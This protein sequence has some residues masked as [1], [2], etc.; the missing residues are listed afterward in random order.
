MKPLHAALVAVAVLSLPCAR[1]RAADVAPE[2]QEPNWP[3]I[4][5]RLRQELYDEPGQARARQQLA[6]AYNNYAIRLSEQGSW[7]LAERQLDEAL[8]LDGGNQ[9]L[10]KNLANI[11]LGQAQAAYERQAVSD[12]LAAIEQALKHDPGLAS[13]Y[14]LLGGIEYD[15]QRLKEAKAAWQ[16][17]AELDPA[18]PDVQK[19][20]QQVT[21]ELPVETKFGR[22]SQASFDLRYEEGVD[23][24]TGFD[25]RD[26]LLQA[27]REV[28]SD[29]SYWPSHKIVVLIYGSESFRKLRQETPEWAAGQFD[30][31]IRVP[32]PAA[33]LEPSAVRRILFHEYAHALIH[34]LSRGRCPLWL[35]EG[36]AEYE[37]RRQAAGSLAHLRGAREQNQMVPW[38]RLSDK[39]QAAQS[40]EEAGG[41]YEE[42]YSIV[43]YVVSRYGFWRFKRLLK[44]FADGTPWEAAFE[45]EL[46]AKVPRLDRSWR[47]WL[48]DFLAAHPE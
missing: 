4:I 5:T 30:G 18:Q 47:E 36:L 22:L 43:A 8:R 29:F 12:A 35:N 16:R 45:A 2:S 21:E 25:I 17:A 20:L 3:S 37:G 28:G 40:G 31:K 48:P 34:D 7:E 23:R 1:A 6:I 32:L 24:P 38:E 11:Y 41:L 9:Q 42:S 26:A 33:G 44:A 15:R 19:R 27:R 14:A 10:H 13:G 39:F 46:H